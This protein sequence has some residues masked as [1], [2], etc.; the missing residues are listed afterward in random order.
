MSTGNYWQ[1]HS[2]SFVLSCDISFKSIEGA[3]EYANAFNVMAESR[4][5]FASTYLFSKIR[6]VGE[7]YIELFVFRNSESFSQHRK[8][9]SEGTDQMKKAMMQHANLDD[10]VI[11]AFGQMSATDRSVLLMMGASV[12]DYSAGFISPTDTV[13]AD[14]RHPVAVIRSF[15]CRSA[16]DAD[17]YSKVFQSVSDQIK[18][19]A[20]TYLLNK[21]DFHK[22]SSTP[23]VS[24]VEVLIYHSPKAVAELATL[25]CIREELTPALERYVDM[26]VNLNPNPNPP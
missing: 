3:E 18:Y 26:Q 21:D 14:G 6:G 20:P 9:V 15:K 23:C 11:R 17:E 10:V 4:H 24:M 7:R 22:H 1:I 25:R 12:F 19:Y 8:R 13:D 16:S 5:D 2:H